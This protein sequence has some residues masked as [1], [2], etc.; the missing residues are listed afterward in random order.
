[1]KPKTAPDPFLDFYRFL[2]AEAKRLGIT[3]KDLTE[4]TSSVT[5][6]RSDSPTATFAIGR[7]STMGGTK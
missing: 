2:L 7:Q 5:P 3:A 1:M 6:D 4:E